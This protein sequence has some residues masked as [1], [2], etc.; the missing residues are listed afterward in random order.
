METLLALLRDGLRPL[1]SSG[2][3]TTDPLGDDPLAGHTALFVIDLEMSGPNPREHEVLELGGVRA[4][5][6][7]GL[8]EE[9]SWGSRVRPRHIGNGELAALKVVGYNVKAW[10]D[11]LELEPAFLKLVETGAGAVIAGWGISGD[12]AFLSETA[13][14][15]GCPWPFAPIAL[16]IQTVARKLLKPGGRVDRFNL[17]HVADRLG[18]GRMGEHSALA[19]AYAT[20]DILVKLA[21]ETS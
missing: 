4:R 6:A 18:I 9:A 2:V 8:E 14:R 5:L 7:P 21:A 20:Y 13:R 16:D 19:D 3:P 1:D 15:T 11:A 17:G 10:K 12:L